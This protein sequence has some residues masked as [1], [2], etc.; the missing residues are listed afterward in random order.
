MGVGGRQSS[1][2]PLYI[3]PSGLIRVP[4][5]ADASVSIL[6]TPSSLCCHCL[7]ES[8]VHSILMDD[9][10]RIQV[11]S[12]V[13]RTRSQMLDEAGISHAHDAC[14]NFRRK[15]SV[16]GQHMDHPEG[17]LGLTA[18]S[19]TKRLVENNTE[20]RERGGDCHSKSYPTA[21]R[22]HT[23]VK[24]RCKMKRKAQGAK[25]AKAKCGPAR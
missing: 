5:L 14:C 6:S 16:H 2:R 8:S 20:L 12:A 18:H 7:T 24:G 22:H 11:I 10:D 1:G 4:R 23:R 17:S 9:Q 3:E 19:G 21:C 13:G 15:S 25:R